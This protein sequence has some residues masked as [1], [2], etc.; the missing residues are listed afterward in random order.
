MHIQNF[1]NVILRSSPRA[2]DALSSPLCFASKAASDCAASKKPDAQSRS[3]DKIFGDGDLRLRN[4][5]RRGPRQT[6]GLSA[7]SS[8][9]A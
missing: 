6:A 8:A 5:G 7:F 9:E 2:M 4:Q 3:W 1:L